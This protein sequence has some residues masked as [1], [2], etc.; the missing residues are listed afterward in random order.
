MEKV[1]FYYRFEETYLDECKEL[2]IPSGNRE[3][4]NFYDLS[5]QF[6]KL[7]KAFDTA[8]KERVPIIVNMDPRISGFD[9]LEVFHF[10][11]YKFLSRKV[12]INNFLLNL[13][14]YREDGKLEFYQYQTSDFQEVYRFFENLILEE[15]LP[16]YS[17]WKY[18]CI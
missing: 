7:K 14:T 13:S 5:E 17:K 16:D 10:I 18:K 1:N 11:K 15:K 6:F 12:K 2:G 8:S 3:L 9:E 4:C